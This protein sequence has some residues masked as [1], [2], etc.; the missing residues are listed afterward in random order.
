M[1]IATDLTKSDIAQQILRLQGAPYSLADYLMFQDIF[2]TQYDRC[3]MRA[4]RQVSKTIT[5][6]SSMVIESIIT[7]YNSLIYVNAS[8]AQ[9]AAF[10]T[11]KLDPFLIHSPVVYSNLMR[12]KHCIN[13]IFNKRFA[14]FSEIRLSYFSES[15]DRVRGFS[16]NKLYLDEIQDIL[17]DAILD[18]EECLSASKNPTFVYAGTSKTLITSLEYFWDLSTQKR[19]VIKCEGCNKYNIPD[20]KNITKEGFV[21]KSCG[22]KLNT[23]LGKWYPTCTGDANDKTCDGYAIPQIIM[24]MHC[25]NPDKW[26]RLWDKFTS[27]PTSRFDNEVMGEPTGEG[28]QLITEELLQE[29]CIPTL[30]MLDHAAPENTK[31]AEYIVAGIDWGGSGMDGV[32][33]TAISIYSVYPNSGEMIKIFCRV[34][35][36]GEPSQHVVDI[37]RLCRVFNV[38]A[39]YGDHGNGN[40]AMSQLHTMLPDKQVVPVMYTE[41]SAPFRWDASGARF[42]VNRTI[43]I[44]SFLLDIKTKKIRCFRYEDFKP[45]GQDL[46][47]V[48]EV[49]LNEDRGISR[50]A[51]RHHPKKSDDVL[52]SMVFGWF[53]ARVLMGAINFTM[54]HEVNTEDTLVFT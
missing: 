6:A 52:H 23:Y 12:S 48:K 10:S 41:Q 8:G 44:D 16:G 17:F 14:N 24:P 53:G 40:F 5:M 1:E 26:R 19:W 50:R 45:F 34:Y 49:F 21:C 15:A 38:S 25:N 42:I 18:A 29:M 11:S 36:A 2:N 30:K 27:Y 20:K 39:I 54:T 37:A 32:S 9:T 35:S 13:N 7:P 4:G 47:N 22:K 31:G 43:L 28:S 3:V 33:R 51:W 46:L